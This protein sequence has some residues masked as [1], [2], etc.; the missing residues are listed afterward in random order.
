MFD[1]I[2]HVMTKDL[3]DGKQSGGVK[4]KISNL[5]YS[6]V[7]FYKPILHALKTHK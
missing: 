4:T 5:A 7:N 2:H 1:L 3:R 6:Y